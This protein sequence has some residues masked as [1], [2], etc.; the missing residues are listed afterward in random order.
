MAARNSPQNAYL[1]QR[2]SMWYI[3][4]PVPPSLR[5]LAIFNGK[6]L[7]IKTLK[8]TDLYEAVICV[9]CF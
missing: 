3:R 8:T 5:N 1:L 2:G 6:A 4:W 9:I 7:H